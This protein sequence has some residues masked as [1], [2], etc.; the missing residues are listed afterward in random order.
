MMHF[1]LVTLFPEFFDSPLRVGLLSKGIKTGLLAC[2]FY[3]PRD[4]ATNKHKYVD[5]SPYGG[6]PGMVMQA[7]PIALALRK[8][9]EPGKMLYLSPRGMPL[10][11]ALARKLAAERDLTLVCGRYEGIDQRVIERFGLTEV[12]VGNFILNGGETAALAVIESVSRFLPGFLGK[13]ESC[14]DES[15]ANGLLEYPQYTRPECF[16]GMNV[17]QILLEGHH[18]KIARWRRDRALELTLER[19]PE[20]LEQARLDRT[21][22]SFLAEIPRS[23]PGRNLSF[24]LF[25]YPIVLENGQSGVSSLT[26]LDIHDIARISRSYGMGR[27]YVLTPL[28]DQLAL[29]NQL[30]EHWRTGRQLDRRRAL[31]LVMPV[32]TFAELDIKA[33][34]THGIRPFYVAASAQWPKDKKAAAP[35]DF[36]AIAKILESRPVVICLGTARGLAREFLRLCDAQLRPLRFLNENHLSV[37]GAAAILADR[38]LGDYL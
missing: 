19:R 11:T 16:E 29:L 14:E 3:N 30:L 34:K 28:R 4:Y 13:T 22:A 2:D 27:F 25:H 15:F 26:N 1:H 7:E 8:I 32:E 17:P 31:E 18:A 21:D 37:R 20:L 23:C 9:P 33:T 36:A 38:I 5:D 35:L 10:T 6:G 12:S 24:A